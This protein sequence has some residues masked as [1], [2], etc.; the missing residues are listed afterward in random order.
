MDDDILTQ[1]AAL[2]LYTAFSLAPLT[3][4][5]ITFLSSF[6]LELQNELLQQVDSIIGSEAVH[7]LETII[8]SANANEGLRSLAGWGSA[9]TL[10]VA[11][12]AIFAQLQS[13]LNH[14]FKSHSQTVLKSNWY[15]DVRSFLRRRLVSFGMVL[16]F[17]FISIVSLTVSSLMSLFVV[18]IGWFGQILDVLGSFILFTGLF[19]SIYKWM[20]D[21]KNKNYNLWLSASVTAALFVLGKALIGS[22]LGGASVGSAYGAAGSFIVLLVWIYYSSLIIFIGAEIS[23]VGFVKPS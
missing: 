18:K 5:L 14:I 6:G 3:I 10:G 20:P 17:I 23:S 2:A 19:A 13:S 12:S 21:K 11:A 4:L 22:Y 16:T 1:A 8:Q 7:V 9:L 15:S